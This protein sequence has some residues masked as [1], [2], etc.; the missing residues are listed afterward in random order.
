MQLRALCGYTILSGFAR[1]SAS[2]ISFEASEILMSNGLCVCPDG[3][4]TDAPWFT[5]LLA[6]STVSYL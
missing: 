4:A 3:F 5:M 2:P 1:H 6:A